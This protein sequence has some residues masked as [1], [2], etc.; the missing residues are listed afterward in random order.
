MD[1]TVTATGCTVEAYV[2]RFPGTHAY[3]PEGYY[4][5]ASV[6]WAISV[7]GEKV[8][9]SVDDAPVNPVDVLTMKM[10]GPN[11]FNAATSFTVSV[12]DAVDV[13]VYICDLRGRVV[14][15]FDVNESR[16]AEV[17]LKWD[18]RNE[19]GESCA[20]G[21]YLAVAESNVHRTEL[22]IVLVK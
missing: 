8:P 13:D 22:K 2:Y 9:V 17:R 18:G 7:L 5:F 1:G 16:G 11:P 12:S 21:V 4:P 15:K 3:I 19:R 20:S 6:T 10:D 14:K